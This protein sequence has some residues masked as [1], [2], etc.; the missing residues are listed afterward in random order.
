M[1]VMALSNE[2]L[3]LLAR[4]SA[5]CD[6]PPWTAIV[7]GRD[8]E[9]GSSFIMV[10]EDQ[11][12][13][14][15]IY[16]IRDSG[17]ADASYL[18]LIAAARTYLPLLVEEVRTGEEQ[19]PSEVDRVSTVLG[20]AEIVAIE[21]RCEAAAPG[22]W[23]SFIEGRDHDSGDDFIRVGE[24]SDQPDMYVH[25]SSHEGTR[26]ASAPDLDFIAAARQDVPRLVAEVR[27]LKSQQTR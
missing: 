16:V 9:S 24:R 25:R 21:A 6:P 26:P 14:E 20:D 15:D 10:G 7:E 12:R 27:R 8:Q 5:R 3:D 13:G 2:T 18:D 22:P 19:D 17:P 11:D 23:K 4:L 1:T